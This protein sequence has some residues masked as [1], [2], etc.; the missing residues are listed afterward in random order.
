LKSDSVAKFFLEKRNFI[1]K[2]GPVV[3]HKIII[4]D[5]HE[6]LIFSCTADVKVI[7]GRPWYRRSIKILWSDFKTPFIAWKNRTRQRRQLERARAKARQEAK[8]RVTEDLFFVDQGWSDRPA[9]KLLNEWLDTLE[10]IVTDAERT[11][12]PQS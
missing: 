11:F 7:R 5:I 3:I 6:T 2:Q 4:A 8:A 10:T 9:L 12:R 1:L